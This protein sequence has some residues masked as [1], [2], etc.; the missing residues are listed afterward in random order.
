MPDARRLSA[1]GL[2]LPRLKGLLHSAPVTESRSILSLVLAFVLVAGSGSA[3]ESISLDLRRQR[4]NIILIIADDM[5]WDDCGAYGHPTLPTPNIDRIANE[6][7]KFNQAF[8]TASSCSPSRASIITSRYPHATGAEQLHWPLPKNQITWVNWLRQSGYWTAAAGKWH[9]GDATKKHFNRVYEA[10]TRGFQLPTGVS[11][12]VAARMQQMSAGRNASGCED[13][14]PALRSCPE[15]R[16]YFLWLAALDPHRDYQENIIPRPTPESDV[17]LPPYI[18]DTPAI[19]RDFARYYD[20][21]RRLDS[22]VGLVLAELDERG[23]A[24]NTF[25]LFISDNG[26]PFPR[27]KTTVY[28]SGVKTPWLVRWPGQI[29][30]GSTTESL[31]STIDIGPT[32]LEVAEFRSKPKTFQGSSFMPVLK[33]PTATVRD[34]VYAERHWH[35]FESYGRAVRDGRYKYIRNYYF[36]LPLTPPADALRSTT[37]REIQRLRDAKMIPKSK[38]VHFAKPRP[39]EELYDLESDPHEMTNLAGRLKHLSVMRRMRVAMDEWR[40]DT[41]DV[42]PKRRTADEFDRETGEPFANRVRPRIPPPRQ[43]FED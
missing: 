39:F 42:L 14:L 22:Y 43:G 41:G 23:E 7:M 33:D 36:D 29:A 21:I 20:E 37:F 16:P 32:L 34:Y 31:V 40:K 1:F 4:P 17:V 12:E 6:G 24:H 19:R 13:W 8:V 27:D 18:P 2:G 10:D 9:L 28:D 5:A 35:D 11:A 30:P 25:I 15:G 38:L 26:R 3:A